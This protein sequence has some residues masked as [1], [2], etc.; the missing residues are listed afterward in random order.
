MGHTA[1]ASVF[2]SSTSASRIAASGG[3]S[4][5]LCRKNVLRVRGAPTQIHRLRHAEVFGEADPLEIG[6]IGIELRAAIHRPVVYDHNL[7]LLAACGF[8]QGFKTCA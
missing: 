4:V 6:K 3:A 1:A 2:A 7:E 8:F 5:S